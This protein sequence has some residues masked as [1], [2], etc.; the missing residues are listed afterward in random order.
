MP[1]VGHE[2]LAPLQAESPILPTA[3]PT[4]ERN[5]SGKLVASWISLGHAYGISSDG[6]IQEVAIRL[7]R[8]IYDAGL[9]GFITRWSWA[10][11]A[12]V[13]GRSGIADEAGDVILERRPYAYHLKERALSRLDLSALNLSDEDLEGLDVVAV[14]DDLKHLRLRLGG[15]E[16]VVKADLKSPPRLSANPDSGLAPSNSS[17]GKPTR[18][19]GSSDST[20]K[21]RPAPASKA[22]SGATAWLRMAPLLIALFGL[23]RWFVRKRGTSPRT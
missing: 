11:N 12:I 8:A 7:P 18:L 16:M 15:R 13:I 17:A 14:G 6:D 10:G 2:L 4:L 23:L 5:N 20:T 9:K 3:V 1:G 21:V 22:P 19:P